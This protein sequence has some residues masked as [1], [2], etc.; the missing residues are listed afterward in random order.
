LRIH[1]IQ[2]LRVFLAVG[3]ASGFEEFGLGDGGWDGLYLSGN[4]RG[5]TAIIAAQIRQKPQGVI[6]L[7]DTSLAKDRDIVER[8]QRRV[9]LIWIALN[10]TIFACELFFLLKHELWGTRWN[11]LDWIAL[12]AS[13]SWLAATLWAQLRVTRIRKAAA[14][15]IRNHYKRLYASQPHEFRIVTPDQFPDLD[16]DFYEHTRAWFESA[17]FRFVGDRQNMT[18]AAIAPQSQTFI[19]SMISADSVVFGGAYH[20]RVQSRSLPADVRDIFFETEFRD[21]TYLI[22]S[23]SPVGSRTPSIHGFTRQPFPPDSTPDAMLYAHNDRLRQILKATSGL[24]AT[25]IETMEDVIQFQH[26][27]RAKKSK[28]K[29]AAGWVGAADIK[30][31]RGP[32]LTEHEQEIADELE[33]LK[34]SGIKK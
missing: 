33:K 1:Y 6:F 11:W 22:T 24:T 32:N 28:A 31:L 25:R 29:E 8:E 15:E 4:P 20:M 10:A 21:G 13:G 14:H 2:Q 17:G 34:K 19:R 12:I 5:S 16:L 27:M 26:R 18:L 7:P 3:P 30:S 23:N 9:T